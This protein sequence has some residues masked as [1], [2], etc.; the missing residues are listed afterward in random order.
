[1]LFKRNGL[2]VANGVLLYDGTKNKGDTIE[3]YVSADNEHASV[4]QVV[5]DTACSATL[6]EGYPLT[7]EALTNAS[8]KVKYTDVDGDK[9][10]GSITGLPPGSTIEQNAD[11][12][13]AN[14]APGNLDVGVYTGITAKFVKAGAAGCTLKLPDMEV[15][16]EQGPN[17]Y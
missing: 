17:P 16:P 7:I 13:T 11:G 5:L 4:S 2:D 3:F 8:F 1:M 6:G 12:M 9:F 14:L 15:K 10:T